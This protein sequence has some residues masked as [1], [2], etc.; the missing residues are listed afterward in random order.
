MDGCPAGGVAYTPA[1]LAARTAYRRAVEVA[2]WGMP[3][4][5]TAA[6]RHGYR[7]DLGASDND[8]AYYSRLP[9]WKFQTT[10][11]N[12]S[13]HYAYS[14]TS[15]K[16]GP[17]VLEVPAAEGA[18]LYG[19]ICDMWDVPLAIVGPGGDDR[20]EGGS[21]LILPPGYDDE[22]P[23]GYLPVWPLTR[24]AFWLMRAIPAGSSQADLDAAIA[25][26][27]KIRMRPLAPAGSPGPQRFVDASG[28]LWDGIPRMDA[29]FYGILAQ[30]VNEEPVLA[31][32]LAMMNVLRSVGIRPGQDF[33]PP[34]EAAAILGDAATEAK[35]FLINQ[36]I[37]AT[38]PFYNGSQWFLPDSTG[39][40]TEFSYQTPELLD[41]DN[42]GMLGFYG[43][44]P[45][46]RADPSAPTIYIQAF[47][48][49]IGRPLTGANI[50]RLRVPAPVPAAQY[51]SL[52]IYDYDTA[53]FIR[54][55]PVISIDS[56]S[57]RIVASG[58]GSI[59]I[60]VA[61]SPPP[62]RKHNWVASQ[63]D[64]RWFAMFRLYGPQK[65]FFDKT[66]RL[67]DFKPEQ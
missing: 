22:P 48:D 20:G 27:K 41:Y 60:Y 1:E 26:L 34:P 57:D 67:P 51:W 5:A 38:E 9:D 25:L 10:T 61:P 28:K 47:N 3:I 15:T 50:F 21:Y 55:A 2:I 24:G 42:R 14:A 63:R 58:D 45:P 8:I 12:A 44:A 43:W 6:I 46:K 32:D 37:T 56:Y 7:R 17:V 65:A 11:P 13:T 54:L 23:P 33:S 59:D 39:L 29:S 35:A 62:G 4:V 31:R 16:A 52:T 40:K 30:M 19:Q 64:G 53:G 18:G 66:W 49:E 36:L